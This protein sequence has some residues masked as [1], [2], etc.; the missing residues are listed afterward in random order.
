MLRSKP[1]QMWRWVSTNPG[2]TIMPV[3]SITSASVA[4]RSRPTSTMRSPSISTSP[5]GRSPIAGSML[6]TRPPLIRV[7]PVGATAKSTPSGYSSGISVVFGG[8]LPTAT[9]RARL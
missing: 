4:V 7:R 5:R 6:S 9:R 8:L 2:I 1:S 3:A